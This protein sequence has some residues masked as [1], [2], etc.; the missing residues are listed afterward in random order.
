MMLRLV[1]VA[2]AVALLLGCESGTST[3]PAAIEFS[4][5]PPPSGAGFVALYAPPVEVG[6]YPTDIYNPVVA[7]TGPTLAVPEK[8]TSPLAAAVNTLDGFSTTAPITAP[9]NAPIDAATLIP[10]DFAAPT[11]SETV[12]V[13]DATNSVPLRPGID[14]E[15]N[16]STAAGANGSVLEI[17]PLMPF[18]P[19]T[20]YAFLL[21]GGIQSTAGV[22]AGADLVFGAVRDAHLAGLTSVPGTPEL[23][24]LFPAITPLIDAGIGLLGLPGDAIVSA[25]SM[26][27]QSIADVL[28]GIETRAVAQPAVLTPA[29]ITTAQV[30]P[31]L[32]GVADVYVGFIEIPYYG[33][34]QD[35]L[36]S[37]WINA[38]LVPPTAADPVPIARVP[39]L[40]IPV[41][42]TVP[43]ADSMQ[44]KPMAGWP[45]VIY[46]HG[47]TTDRSTLFA[48]ADAFAAQGFAAIAIDLPLHGITD[49]ANPFFQ[50]PGNPSPLN[51]FGDNERHF[52]L[53]TIDAVGQP[54]PDGAIDDGRQIFNIA[55][56][57]NGRDHMR[58]AAAD[59]IYLTKTIPT[60]DIDGGGPDFDGGRIHLVGMSLGAAFASI[61]LGV[62]TD[63][64]PATMASSFATWSRILTDPQALTFGAPLRAGLA[65]QGLPSGTAGFDN[66]VRDLQTVLDSADPANYAEA[67]S[68]LH[69][70]HVI[71]ILGDVT[72]PNGPTDYLADLWNLADVTAASPLLVE[73]GGAHGIVRFTSGDHGSLLDPS[74]DPAVTLEM[75]TEMVTFA[76]SGGTTIAVSDTSVV[77]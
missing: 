38:G 56:P 66:F 32:P 5:P 20:T 29:G 61:M 28:D 27:T 70:L 65:A 67:T 40:R 17:V 39:A 48:I 43:G 47:V 30:N 12:F 68:T 14:Y 44:S 23:D 1:S 64:G 57:I 9:F 50:G 34:P 77:Q 11:G 71:E 55:N 15:L 73:P 6:P 16:V 42:A 62:N 13:L 76:V 8:I 49:P 54:V 10:F 21:T 51:A 3:G 58:Q 22:A 26:T 4:P 72:V 24:P 52:Y 69:G 19:Q 45:I 63:V 36:G 59:L 35:T 37:V 41:L 2:A 75:Q 46:Q 25:W 31:M 53:D 33:D 74:A 18:A 7:G 60:L